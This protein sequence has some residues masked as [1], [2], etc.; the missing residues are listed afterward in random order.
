LST[1]VQK[2]PRSRR[3]Y[4][5]PPFEED[6]MFTSRATRLVFF[7]LASMVADVLV[8]AAAQTS[9]VRPSV[10]PRIASPIDDSI[11]V[12]VPQSTHPMA[13]PA[14]DVGPV[15]GA[16]AFQRMI[17]VLGGNPD[18]EYQARTLVDS[19]QTKGSPDYHHWLTPEEFGQKF[20]PS[21]EDI[22]QVTGWLQQHGFN[23]GN[24]ARSGRWIE[25]SGTSAQVE[26]AFQ[27][28][29]RQYLVGGDCTLPMRRTYPSRPPYRRLYAACSP[30]TTFTASPCSAVQKR[31]AR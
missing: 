30:C 3:T 19:Q 7:C 31:K 2:C 13:K 11:R 24:V 5:S 25:F 14:F 21:P 17:L 1:F 10:A 6:S 28:R 9:A 29:M 15:D 20:G 16:T 4:T 12:T 23:V 8:P 18:Q 27:T 26:A 22:A